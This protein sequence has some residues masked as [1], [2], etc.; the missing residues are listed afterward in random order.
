[1]RR[2]VSYAKVGL[3]SDRVNLFFVI[4]D[5]QVAFQHFHLSSSFVSSKRLL[6]KKSRS[7]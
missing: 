4:S 7:G 6:V 5:E 2:H 1:M 3:E